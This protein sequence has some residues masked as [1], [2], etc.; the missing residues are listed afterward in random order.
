MPKALENSEA[1]SVLKAHVTLK[2]VEDEYLNSIPDGELEAVYSELSPE[3][4]SF[5]SKEADNT[6]ATG[7]KTVDDIQNPETGDINKEVA[8]E[9]ITNY[10]KKYSSEAISESSNFINTYSFINS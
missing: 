6:F 10:I 3:I 4:L 5:L 8:K 9:I 7:I 2:T 1:E